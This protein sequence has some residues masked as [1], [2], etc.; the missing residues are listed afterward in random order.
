MQGGARPALQVIELVRIPYTKVQYRYSDQDYVFYAY[1]SE[2]KEKFYADRFPARWDRIER[3][4]KA[5]STDLL[6]P[7]QKDPSQ[8][9]FPPNGYGTSGEYSITEEDDTGERP[10]DYPGNN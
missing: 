8:N 9:N 1:D 4:V 3:L 2:N 5:I 7:G 6:T 10:S